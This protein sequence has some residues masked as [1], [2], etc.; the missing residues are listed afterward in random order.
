VLYAAYDAGLDDADE[1]TPRLVRRT[2]LVFLL[3]Q[4]MRLADLARLAGRVPQDE[5]TACMRNVPVQP[6][7]AFEQIDPMPPA[8]RN[9][10]AAG[11]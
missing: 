3:R 9:L 2:Y 4:G 7:V 6:R 10:D 8:L 5:L 1:V 11:G